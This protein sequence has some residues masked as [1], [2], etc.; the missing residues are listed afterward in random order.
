MIVAVGLQPA[1]GDA[2]H[3]LGAHDA[4][5]VDAVFDLL[6]VGSTWPENFTSPTPSAR[7]RPGRA[8]P[9][10]EEAEHLPQRVEAEAARHHRI[11]LEM[12]GEE[13]EVG[14]DV[15]LGAHVALAVLAARLGDLA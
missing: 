6:D 9:A 4:L 2:E 12:A 3:Q 5:E 7:P 1:V 11:A 14:L 13:P 8:E 10:E 15:E